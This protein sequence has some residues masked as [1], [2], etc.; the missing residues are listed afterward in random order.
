[1][2]GKWDLAMLVYEQSMQMVTEHYG[3]SNILYK[4]LPKN[5]VYLI[6][7]GVSAA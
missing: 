6:D 4:T 1:M 5:L 3:K 2:A 7:Q